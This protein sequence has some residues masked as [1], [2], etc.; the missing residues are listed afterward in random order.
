MAR[1]AAHSRQQPRRPPSIPHRFIGRRWQLNWNY[2]LVKTRKIQRGGR[3]VTELLLF[4]FLILSC[5]FSVVAES[6]WQWKN[7]QKEYQREKENERRMKGEWKENRVTQE[8]C[9]AAE[10]NRRL[11]KRPTSSHNLFHFFHHFFDYISNDFFHFN[12]FS[13]SIDSELNGNGNDND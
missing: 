9:R 8:K 2:R 3:V 12:F 7:K 4:F 6:N 5:L 13:S 10:F 11:R 1:G